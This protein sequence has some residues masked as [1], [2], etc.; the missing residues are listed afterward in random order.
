MQAGMKKKSAGML[1]GWILCS[2]ALS[3]CGQVVSE[4]TVESA[5]KVEQE[6]M[7]E[8]SVT[9]QE[10][11]VSKGRI[12]VFLPGGESDTRWS[13]DAGIMKEALTQEGYFTSV[14]WAD[15]DPQLQAS[16][17]E[18][19]IQEE[20]HALVIAP[21]DG[22]AL[23]E[24]LK[25]TAETDIE[26][27][28]YDRLIMNTDRLRYFITFD[29]RAAG[30]QIGKELLKRA[31][32]DQEKLSQQTGPGQEELLQEGAG[33]PLTIE[34]FMGDPDSLSDRFF[35][36]GVLERLNP[37]LEAG[38][39][40]CRSQET[41]FDEN[42]T[43]DRDPALALARYQEIAD[44]FYREEKAPDL[45]VTGSDE[46]AVALAKELAESGIEAGSPQWPLITGAG[47]QP[48]GLR[49][50]AA[51]RIGFT[52]F[53]D[54]RN[55]AEKAVEVVRG[56]LDDTELK[57]SNYEQYDNGV[58]IV[59]TM[60]CSSKLIDRENVQ[61]MVENGYYPQTEIIPE[62][63][64]IVPVT[65]AEPDAQTESQEAPA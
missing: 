9:P 3:G 35:Q 29:T 32:L 14:F 57:G 26:V 10:V 36:N 15:E 53:M 31:G 27:F 49:Y 2:L 55:L 52:V 37:Y 50:T 21:V 59:R 56:I 22:Y 54:N 19:Y 64:L 65:E 40:V 28:S 48:E 24:T 30:K 43:S 62:P 46:I 63:E 1:T 13:Q 45:I 5:G 11:P 58:K 4:E 12:G 51:G 42:S 16:Q 41:A 18:T 7:T 33:D 34:F 39:L 8:I 44:S 47:A 25:D 23:S 6:A 61:V 60:T 17:I 20:P 38:V